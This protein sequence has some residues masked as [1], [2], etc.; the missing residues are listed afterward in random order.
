MTQSTVCRALV[1]ASLV[2]PFANVNAG[3][4]V[5]SVGVT[6]CRGVTCATSYMA[7]G[8]AVIEL[9]GKSPRNAGNMLD[10]IVYHGA[11]YE[12]AY[13]DTLEVPAAGD[14]ALRVPL[15]RL[16]PG[17]YTF[18][19]APRYSGVLLG[20]GGFTTAPRVLPHVPAW[21]AAQRNTD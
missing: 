2:L 3:V 8:A 18:S 7:G 16:R 20:A 6:A 10:L 17:S 5:D 1:V 4:D 9:R 19:V 21:P 13:Y 11:N 14:F 12:I 15:G